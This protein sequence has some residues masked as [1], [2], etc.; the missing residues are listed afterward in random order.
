VIRPEGIALHGLFIESS[1]TEFG[2]RWFAKLKIQRF[3]HVHSK[4]FGSRSRSAS[5][6]GVEF[7][8]RRSPERALEKAK[9]VAGYIVVFMS[10]R[11]MRYAVFKW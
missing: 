3:D 1:R 11:V 7:V 2:R 4:T 10:L 9:M 5:M 8:V 6:L